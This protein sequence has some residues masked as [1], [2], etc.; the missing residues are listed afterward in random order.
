M[1]PVAIK[2]AGM[3]VANVP[4]VCKTPP[5]PPGIPIP[6][7]NMGMCSFATGTT[8]K[9]KVTGAPAIT[10]SSKL[11]R[12]T[13]DEPG[14]M[15]GVISQTVM[16]QVAFKKGSSKVSFEGSD[17]VVL[18]LPTAHNGSNA[19]APVGMFSVPGQMI[20]TAAP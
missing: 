10:V 5:P 11:S 20:V 8:T 2:G 6:Y 12:S 4:D 15:K 14:V 19:N 9:V 16:D 3:C 17:V 7:P 13:G 1:M 18:N